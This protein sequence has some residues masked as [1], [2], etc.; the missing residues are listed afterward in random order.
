MN[1]TTNK[2]KSAPAGSDPRPTSRPR[3]D[4][5]IPLGIPTGSRGPQLFFSSLAKDF[6]RARKFLPD[7]NISTTPGYFFL[8]SIF[9][10]WRDFFLDK[11]NILAEI[12]GHSGRKTTFVEKH[13][14][15]GNYI[16][17][18]MLSENFSFIAPIPKSYLRWRFWVKKS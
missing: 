2:K 13:F 17:C 7:P 14:F 4:P 8:G 1:T 3:A 11:K 5:G 18:W 16:T 10:S 6:C 9:F 15:F 12:S